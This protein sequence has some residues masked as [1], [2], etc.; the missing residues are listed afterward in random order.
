[1]TFVFTCDYCGAPIESN[2]ATIEISAPNRHSEPLR[3]DRHYHTGGLHTK[4][5]CFH[6]VLDMLDGVELDSP[7]AGWEWKLVPIHEGLEDCAQVL[8]TTPLTDLAIDKRVFAVLYQAGIRTVEHAADL[9]DRNSTVRGLG[10]T[11]AMKLD[12]ALAVW[13]Q[14]RAEHAREVGR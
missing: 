13:R 12:Q 10:P 1:M 14:Q 3:R 5:G 7:S 4:D 6:R 2:W 9:R 8:G 11:V